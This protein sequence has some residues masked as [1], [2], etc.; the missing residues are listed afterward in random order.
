MVTL[1]SCGACRRLRSVSFIGMVRQQEWISWAY[2]REG[3]VIWPARVS[4]GS[5]AEIARKGTDAGI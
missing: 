4:E 3:G 2:L 5:D 1:W